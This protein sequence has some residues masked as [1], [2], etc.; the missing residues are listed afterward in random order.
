MF[1]LIITAALKRW[2]AAFF[3]SS[4]SLAQIETE[5][6]RAAKIGECNAYG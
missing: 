2:A 5:I 1:G 4:R 6:K 3:I